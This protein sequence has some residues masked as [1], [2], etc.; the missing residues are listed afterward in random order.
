MSPAQNALYWREIGA[1]S[2]AR[3]AR[4]LP[5]DSAARHAVHVKAL[6]ADK[7]HLAFRN[8]EFD[9]VLAALRAESRPDDL[10]AQI[11]QLEQP[12]E[13]KSELV[14]RIPLL[15]MRC[16]VSSGLAGAYADGISRKIFGVDQFHLLDERHLNQL[17]G[18]LDQRIRQI[19]RKAAKVCANPNPF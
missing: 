7:S 12:E 16:G 8:P 2:R 17:A 4:G 10:N 19:K 13:R 1:W 14:G 5:V 15:V 3:K 6:G 9:R 11:R 18:V